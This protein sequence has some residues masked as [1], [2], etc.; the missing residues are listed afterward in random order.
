MTRATSRAAVAAA[1]L[2]GLAL[3]AGCRQ[4]HWACT[5]NLTRAVLHGHTKGVCDGFCCE[6]L[7]DRT[8]VDTSACD[9]SDDCP[10]HAGEVY[11]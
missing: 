9:C 8:A 6:D 10:C 11:R 3:L 1:L 5:D 4:Q 2:L 7:H